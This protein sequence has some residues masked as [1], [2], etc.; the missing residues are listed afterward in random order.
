MNTNKKSF[1]LI[2]RVSHSFRIFVDGFTFAVTFFFR[3]RER[4]RITF[5]SKL[6]TKL[7]TTINSRRIRLVMQ[8]KL[9]AN[10]IQTISSRSIRL[11]SIAQEIKKA[12]T[13]IDS[14][15]LIVFISKATQ[16]AVVAMTQGRFRLITSPVLA[17]FFTLGTYDPSTLG[18]L[19]T[20]TLGDMDYIS[21]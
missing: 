18:T 9:I 10:V 12:V 13:T 21:T 7:T 6:R 14:D 17:Q 3:I 16:K 8:S 1:K 20:E 4:I 2:N 11:T 5:I 19:D 15:M